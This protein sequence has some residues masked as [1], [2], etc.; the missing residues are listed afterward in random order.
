MKLTEL[1]VPKEKRDRVSGWRAVEEIMRRR[2]TGI[3]EMAVIPSFRLVHSVDP[4][5]PLDA[6]RSPALPV[7]ERGYGLSLVTE[8]GLE[9]PRDRSVKKYVRAKLRKIMQVKVKQN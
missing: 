1:Y 7:G 3:V 5:T 9:R 2:L 4:A 6:R 8:R